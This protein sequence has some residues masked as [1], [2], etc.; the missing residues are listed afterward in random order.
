MEMLLTSKVFRHSHMELVSM[1]IQFT[2]KMID[3]EVGC[4]RYGEAEEGIFI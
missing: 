3:L 1:S 2:S 4:L